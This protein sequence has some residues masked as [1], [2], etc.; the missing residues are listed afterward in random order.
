MKEILQISAKTLGACALPDSCPR[1]LW[2]KLKLGNRL[3]FQVFP[4]IFAHIDSYCKNIVHSSFDKYKKTPVWLREL[5]EFKGYINVP[6]FSKFNIMDEKY[7]IKLTGAPDDVLL[8]PN[9]L[10][11][12][13]DYKTAKITETQDRLFPMYAVQLNVYYLIATQLGLCQ[14]KDLALVYAEPVSEHG[15][16]AHQKDG[17][18]MNFKSKIVPV[19]INV[20]IVQSLLWKIREIYDMKNV[21]SGRK[22]CKDCLRLNGLIDAT[23]FQ[24]Q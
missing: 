10:C 2:I 3:P 22:G 14:V 23:N 16:S 7:N 5:G 15:I 12:I 4:S 11:T 6:H 20:S 17:F 13:I 8:R 9:N 24:K 18:I 19:N 21:P 1:C